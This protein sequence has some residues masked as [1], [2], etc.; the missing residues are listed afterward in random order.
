[1]AAFQNLKQVLE[2]YEEYL[3]W[4]KH[5]IRLCPGYVRPTFVKETSTQR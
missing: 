4:G 5:E 1:M 2:F 3:P